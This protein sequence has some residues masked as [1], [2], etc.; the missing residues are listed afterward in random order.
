MVIIRI[1]HKR[2]L[3]VNPFLTDYFQIKKGQGKG[4]KNFFFAL[5]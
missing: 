4:P 1:L 3:K 5:Q 2:Y